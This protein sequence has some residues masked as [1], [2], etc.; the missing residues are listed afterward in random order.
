MAQ[1]ARVLLLFPL[2]LLAASSLTSAA[3]F[4]RSSFPPDFIFGAGSAAYQYEAGSLAGGINKKGVEFYNNLINELLAHGM[5][6]FITLFHF[7]T[8]QG[9]ENKYGGFLSPNIVDDYR[10]FAEAQQK[11]S[12]GITLATNWFKPFTNSKADL[13]AQQRSLDFMFGW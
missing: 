5:K 8:P 3:A 7:D 10:D 2:L 11:G 4:N 12:I 9:L 1:S 6:P 13:L